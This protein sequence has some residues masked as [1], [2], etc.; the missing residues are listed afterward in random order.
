VTYKGD[1]LPG[2]QPPIVDKRLFDAVQDRL[3]QQRNNWDAV[4]SGS[5][6]LLV[7]KIFDETG[8]RM[9]PSHT[10]KHGAKYRY[11]ISSEP[12]QGQTKGAGKLHRIP[13]AEVE[14]AVVKAL[15]AK[16]EKSSSKGS[17]LIDKHVNRITARADRL[18]IELKGVSLP[19]AGRARGSKS[20]G[21]K[22]P[23]AGVGTFSFPNIKQ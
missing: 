21:P 17:A 15:Q 8:N 16:L 4:Y 22:R 5:E 19:A 18:I 20:C 14:Q 6:A 12:T 23:P 7:G 2:E 10:R 9:T 1:I 13:A 3:N 11:Y